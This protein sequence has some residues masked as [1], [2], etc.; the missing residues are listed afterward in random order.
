M[1]IKNDTKWDAATKMI[2]RCGIMQ[3]AA[4]M[5]FDLATF[6]RYHGIALRLIQYKINLTKR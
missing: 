1:L 4:I 6:Y 5:C 3:D 2:E